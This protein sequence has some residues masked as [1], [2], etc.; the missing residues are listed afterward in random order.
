MLGIYTRISKDRVN[1]VSTEVQKEEGVKLS[2]RLKVP[3]KLYEEA[4]GTS[5]GKSIDERPKLDNL[6]N[7]IYDNKITAVYFYNQDRSARDEVTWFTLANLLIE[8]NVA[9]YEN[10]VLVN[11]NDSDTYML[12][13]FKAIM[14]A[15]ERRKTGK[16]IKDALIKLAKDGKATNP[17]LTY[18]YKKDEN[19]YLAID[20]DEASIVKRIFKDSLIGKGSTKISYELNDDKIPTR[21]AKT[22]KGTITTVNKVSGVV[23]TKNKSNVKWSANTVLQIIKNTWYFGERK[24]KGEIFDV[25]AIVSKDYWER[26]NDNLQNNKISV[27]KVTH[28]YLLRGVLKCDCGGNMYGKNNLAKRENYYSCSSKRTRGRGCGS[29][30]INKPRLDSLIWSRFFGHELLKKMV[31]EHFERTDEKEMINEL[32]SKLRKLKQQLKAIEGQKTNTITFASKEVISP[33]EL[34]VQL[35]RIRTDKNDIEIQILNAESQ[36]DSYKN[37]I[38]AS[39]GI[40]SELE[41]FRSETSFN[42]KKDIIKKYISDII[43]S[44]KY[45]HF[46]IQVDFNIEGFESY[47]LIV[48]KRFYYAI[49]PFKGDFDVINKYQK[50]KKGEMI[51]RTDEEFFKQEFNKKRSLEVY[52]IKYEL[53]QTM[54]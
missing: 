2:E 31:I 10:G 43:I 5:G 12:A 17:V 54:M 23:T 46:L 7:D 14:N 50:I 33:E 19:G 51:E 32:D 34:E 40:A 1:Q 20:E 41:S 36:L 3:Y 38:K 6:V 24:Y 27:G 37:I 52:T 49:E 22:A 13:G 30:S 42:D 29:P 11:L 53:L 44:Y 15:A 35:K 4:K 47:F 39:D 9:L 16:K 28:K 48:Q 21:Y 25:P 8:K 18:G 26:V 45:N